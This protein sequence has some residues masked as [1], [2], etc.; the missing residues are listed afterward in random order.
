VCEYIYMNQTSVFRVS[1]NLFHFFN[2]LYFFLTV[3]ARLKTGSLEPLIFRC[4]QCLL[5]DCSEIQIV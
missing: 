3:S 1:N 4:V 2:V 5:V